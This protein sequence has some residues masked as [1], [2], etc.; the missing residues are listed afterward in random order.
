MSAPAKALSVRRIASPGTRERHSIEHLPGHRRAHRQEDGA[1]GRVVAGQPVGEG[2]GVEVQRVEDAVEHRPPERPL[3][4][5]PRVLGD[6]RDVGNLFHEHD[7]VHGPD[8]TGA[9]GAG[10]RSQVTRIGPDGPPPTGRTAPAGRTAPQGPEGTPPAAP[11]D[12][13][14]A[15]CSTATPLATLRP[16]C[17]PP[18]SSSPGSW[19]GSSPRCPRSRPSRSGARAARRVSAPT[20]PPTSTSTSTP[21]AT[22]P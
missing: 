14:D 8:S 13:E 18:T 1:A 10:Q 17:R 12:P 5:V 7:A 9:P 3:L 22:S 2:E 4:P 6:V 19:P 20:T 21:G 16:P 15:R 11:R